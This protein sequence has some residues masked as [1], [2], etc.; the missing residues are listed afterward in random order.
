[1]VNTVHWKSPKCKAILLSKKVFP[2]LKIAT[3]TV[4]FATTF[5]PFANK[6]SREV[7]YLQ[8][9][10]TSALSKQKEYQLPI[11]CYFNKVKKEIA[12]LLFLALFFFQ[13]EDTLIMERK[14]ASCKHGVK[15]SLPCSLS[16]FFTH[17]Y[18]GLTRKC[19]TKILRLR[20]A[21]LRLNFGILSRNWDWIFSLISSPAFQQIL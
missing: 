8:L 4:A 2:G 7:A 17:K 19:S 18:C 13:S 16:G 21:K 9:I 15:R 20:V 10:F 12:K 3:N 6:I 5:L 1:M 14:L 11:C